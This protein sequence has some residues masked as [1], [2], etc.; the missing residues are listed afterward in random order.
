MPILIKNKSECTGCGAC[1]NKCPHKCIEMKEDDCGFIY[2]QV[3]NSKCT[4]CELCVKVCPLKNELKS[5]NTI[6]SVYASW[7]KNP[8][9]R[10]TSTSGGVF[11]E[12]AY[13]IIAMGGAVS[14]AVYDSENNI[15]HTLVYKQKDILR[16]RQS[17]YAQSNIC[18]TFMR[19]KNE[20]KSKPVLFCGTPCQT[21]GLIS[22]L[23]GHPDKLFTVDFICRG[24]N[25][26]KAYREW[27][28]ELEENKNSKVSRVW[29]KY[30]QDGW[31]KSPKCTRIDFEDK[32]HI[33]Q[34]GTDNT[35]MCGYLGANLYIRK[36]CGNCK[37]KGEKRFGDITVGD[38]WGI[39]RQYDDDR[40]TSLVLIN[41]KHGEELFENIKSKLFIVERKKE[42]ILGGNVCFNNS[43]NINPESENFLRSLGNGIPFSRLVRNYT[44]VSLTVRAKR[45]IKRIIKK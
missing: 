22:F 32:T 30:K 10:M 39:D 33:V 36:S 14:G 29:F 31:K 35:F 7:S 1:F 38:F 37:F 40:G 24:V 11:S 21:A 4:N 3:D 19:I 2:P 6:K 8:K 28:K 5:E 12:L 17:K 15:C 42:E 23:G 9:T 16:I 26:P 44:K 34:K 43:V 45:C 41:S 18:D 20:L 27:L 13:G 25:S